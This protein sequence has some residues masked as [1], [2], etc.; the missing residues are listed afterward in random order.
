MKKEICCNW[1]DPRLKI[2]LLDFMVMEGLVN[3]GDVLVLVIKQANSGTRKV[4]VEREKKGSLLTK[5]TY[6]HSHQVE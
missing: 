3:S 5:V 4:H 6:E 1:D 2:G